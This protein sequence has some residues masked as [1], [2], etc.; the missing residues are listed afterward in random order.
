MAPE[1]RASLPGW[2]AR[3]RFGIAY[4][5][6]AKHE[7]ADYQPGLAAS[8]VRGTFVSGWKTVADPKDLGKAI[9]RFAEAKGAVFLKRNVAFATA[10]GDGFVIQLRQGRTLQ[11]RRLIVAAGA[12][13]HL[14]AR[15]FG[16]IVP[17]ET[18]RGYNTTLT[19][20]AFNVRRQLI[21]SGHGFVITPL[22]TG[23]RVGGAVGIGG[24]NRPPNFAARRPCSKKR[25]GSCRDWIPAADANA[26][27]IAPPCRIHGQSSAARVS[28]QT[29]FMRSATDISA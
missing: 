21:F 25:S 17:L 27:A 3:D 16:D 10:S 18:E 8:F 23:L 5:H 14:L 26:W 28:I 24:L 20:G 11:S 1:F 13:S 2:G 15:R 4:R 22:A 12:W 9:W 6:V 19:K 29:P 7:L